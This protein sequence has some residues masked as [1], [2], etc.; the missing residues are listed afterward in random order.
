MK[1]YFLRETCRTLKEVSPVITYFTVLLLCIMTWPRRGVSLPPNTNSI[2]PKLLLA[3]QPP[4]LPDPPPPPLERTNRPIRLTLAWDPSPS[5]NV[6][7]YKLYWGPNTGTYTNSLT[8]TGFTAVIT[9]KPPV[10]CAVTAMDDTGLESDFSDEVR[11]PFYGITKVL[12]K[13]LESEELP[14]RAWSNIWTKVLTNPPGSIFW[15]VEVEK[16]NL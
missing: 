8:V 9:S 5:T 1:R 12:I 11:F 14:A 13:L 10:F 4:P 2:N 3:T 6:I 16:I 15:K 7:G